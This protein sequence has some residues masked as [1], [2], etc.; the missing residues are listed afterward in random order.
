MKVVC[1]RKCEV[2]YNREQYPDEYPACGCKTYNKANPADEGKFKRWA[3]L[4]TYP[5]M[6]KDLFD[7]D[8]D[9]IADAK[10]SPRHV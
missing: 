7:D 8:S 10:R 4:Q 1:C 9:G 5:D 6:K 3:G 2:I